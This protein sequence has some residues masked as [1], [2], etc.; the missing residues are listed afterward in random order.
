MRGGKPREKAFLLYEA[1]NIL[2]CFTF[3]RKGKERYR[4]GLN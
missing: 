1:E 2:R 4:M 3:Y